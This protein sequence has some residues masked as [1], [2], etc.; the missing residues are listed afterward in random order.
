[1]LSTGCRV[2]N[3][4][5]GDLPGQFPE[6]GIFTVEGVSGDKT[7][8]PRLSGCPRQGSRPKQKWGWGP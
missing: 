7:V 4:G 6:G 2:H 5:M 3:D 8:S 1:M